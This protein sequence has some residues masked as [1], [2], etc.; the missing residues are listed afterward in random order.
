M[1]DRAVPAQIDVPRA[2]SEGELRAE[3]GVISSTGKD[4]RAR[5]WWGGGLVERLC[6]LRDRLVSCAAQARKLDAGVRPIEVFMCSIVNKMGY[7]DGACGRV[8]M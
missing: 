7:A 4:V 6:S 1:G 3:L 2:A 8:V 5:C